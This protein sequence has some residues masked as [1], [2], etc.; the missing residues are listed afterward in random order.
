MQGKRSQQEDELARRRMTREGQSQDNEVPEE[1]PPKF[2]WSD[3]L[4]MIIAAYQVLF[5]MLLIMV[6]VM[7]VFYLLFQFVFS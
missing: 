5:P 1:D 7:A 3:T 4:A 6:G 2:T